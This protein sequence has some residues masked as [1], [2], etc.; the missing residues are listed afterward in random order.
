MQQYKRKEKITTHRGKSNSKTVK[1]TWWIKQ[2]RMIFGIK[3]E[4]F[5]GGN[6]TKVIDDRTVVIERSRK[7][8]NRRS[9]ENALASEK[10]SIEWHSRYR[11]HK[12]VNYKITDI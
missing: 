1:L 5:Y 7:F 12:L 11:L 4:R 6:R 3:A 10:K 2:N 8:K 9:A